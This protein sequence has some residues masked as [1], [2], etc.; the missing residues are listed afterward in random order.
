MKQSEKIEK[1]Q[2]PMGLL[3]VRELMEQLSISRST[4]Y[5]LEQSGALKPAGRLGRRVFYSIQAVKDSLK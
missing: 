1:S 2:N 4:L 3:T 5:R